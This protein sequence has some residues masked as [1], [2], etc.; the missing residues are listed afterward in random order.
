MIKNTIVNKIL[1]LREKYPELRDPKNGE[2]FY[3]ICD[4]VLSE[5]SDFK[6]EFGVD[7]NVKLIAAS[8]IDFEIYQNTGRIEKLI[9][10]NEK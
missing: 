4:K 2:E 3:N 6:K 7:I 9:T 5:L 1:G 10:Y 8:D